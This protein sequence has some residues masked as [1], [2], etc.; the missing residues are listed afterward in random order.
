MEPT[1]PH[2]ISLERMVRAVEKVRIRLLR[3]VKVL[4]D[5]S[6][7]YAVIG[8]NAVAAWVSR[9][10]EAAVR[11]TPDVNILIRREDLEEVIAAFERAGFA[12][13]QAKESETTEVHCF[14]E[15]PN[16]N[17][18]A[19]IHLVM[20]REDSISQDVSAFPDISD[21]E[22]GAEFQV[23]SLQ[24]LVEMKLNSFRCKDRT[25]LRD[26]IEVGLIDATWPAK[27]PASLAARLQELL[28]DPNG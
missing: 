15:Q 7:P 4:E 28:D 19:A 6:L 18:R 10:D 11:N 8:G 27:F 16:G 25:H 26:M 21:S 3:A 20:A 23:I 13:D 1:Y 2:P 14:L 5:A 9:I 24:A 22:R 17:A 12:Y